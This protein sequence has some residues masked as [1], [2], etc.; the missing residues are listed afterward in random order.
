MSFETT[1]SISMCGMQGAGKRGG[2][3]MQSKYVSSP[4][5]KVEEVGGVFGV[6]LTGAQ[7]SQ[8]AGPRDSQIALSLLM[9]QTE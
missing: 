5:R 3:V 1:A 6:G 7:G 9:F 8:I 4:G 2:S